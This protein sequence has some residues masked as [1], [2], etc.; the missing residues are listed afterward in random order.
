MSLWVLNIDIWHAPVILHDAETH[1][2]FNSSDNCVCP[3][4]GTLGC[5]Y[6]HRK[7]VLCALN[8]ITGYRHLQTASPNTVDSFLWMR[9]NV[10]CMKKEV[11]CFELI[12]ALRC[13]RNLSCDARSRSV[14]VC[15]CVRACVRVCVCVCVRACVCVCVRARS[16]VC[17][18]V[19][20]C[21]RASVR[22]CVSACMRVHDYREE[23]VSSF[24]LVTMPYKSFPCCLSSRL[25]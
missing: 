1:L 23:T 16:F 7:W 10:H 25:Q 8:V 2:K 12:W 9:K 5:L 13:C 11:W 22:A 20:V 6:T 21:V 15:E 17:V 4:I 19:C 18:C 24:S 3:F 14:C